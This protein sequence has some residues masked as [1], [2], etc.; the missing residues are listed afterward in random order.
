MGRGPDVEVTA[1]MGVR[2]ERAEGGRA[3]EL[4]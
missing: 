4:G 1:L 2:R 3:E